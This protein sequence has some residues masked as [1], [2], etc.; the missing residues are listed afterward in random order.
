MTLIMCQNPWKVIAQRV[1]INVCKFKKSF[2]KLG[3]PKM[4][5]RM[6]PPQNQTVLQMYEINSMKGMRG[7]D[8]DLT[9]LGTEWRLYD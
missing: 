1:N 6:R 8:A 2:R 4:K 3:H 7:K 9:N 5:Y